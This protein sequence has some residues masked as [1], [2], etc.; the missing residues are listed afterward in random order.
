MALQG[1]NRW[2]G[3][4]EMQG[5]AA[6]NYLAGPDM[7]PMVRAG[8]DT[9]LGFEPMAKAERDAAPIKRARIAAVNFMLWLLGR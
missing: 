6:Q 1:I 5:G 3:D 9:G 8:L 7:L 4:S 2:C